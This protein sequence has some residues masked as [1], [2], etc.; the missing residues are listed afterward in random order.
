M[1]R[2]Q[3]SASSNPKDEDLLN[4]FLGGD[5]RAFEVLIR[6]HEDRIFA[7]AL[8]M[9]G[10]RADALEAAQETFITAFRQASSFR[11]EAAFGTWLYRV[12]IN[13][14]KDLLRKRARMPV[15]EAE[16]LENQRGG[17]EHDV[18]ETVAVRMD[19][20]RA[21]ASIPEEYREAV[22]LH[23]LGGFR[24]EEIARIAGVPVGTIKSR[25]SRGRRLL[26]LRLEHRR[27]IPTSKEQS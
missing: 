4:R 16:P 18:G 8:K 13:A 22:A 21:L 6:R 1:Q 9:M 11:G 27:R 7:L 20:S 15:P 5:Q 19:V 24:Y 3:K 10:D 23:D 17:S 2:Y 25:I 12:G 14:C 26:A